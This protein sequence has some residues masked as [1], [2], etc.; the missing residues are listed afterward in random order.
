MRDLVLRPYQEDAIRN[1]LSSFDKPCSV[2]G[3]AATG[4][5]KTVLFLEIANRILSSSSEARVL[6]CAHRRELIQQPLE[7]IGQFWPHMIFDSGIVMSKKNDAHKR[8][9]VGTMQ[10]LAIG[11]RLDGI[12]RHGPITHIIVDEAHR[13]GSNS[14]LSIIDKCREA[15]N[16]LR[17]LGVTATP[18]RADGKLAD[19]FDKKCFDYGTKELIDLGYLV[20]PTVMGVYTDISV[21]DVSVTGSGVF[22]D[23]Q[24]SSLSSVFE[25]DNCFDQ[26]VETHAKYAIDK[27]GISFTVTVAGAY[28]LAEKFNEYGVS[29]IALDGT[30]SP[31]ERD[32]AISG[33]KSGRYKMI[34]NAMLYTEGFDL[35][36][37]EVCHLVRPY[38]QDGPWVQCVGRVLRLSPDTGKDAALVFDYLPQERSLEFSL[39]KRVR[40]MGAKIHGKQSAGC[41]PDDTN[42][43]PGF[44]I[45]GRGIEVAV[46]DYFNEGKGSSK[47]WSESESGWRVIGLGESS[48]EI[49]RTLVMSPSGEEMELWAVWKKPGERWNQAGLL[50]SGDYDQVISHGEDMIRKHGSKSLVGRNAEWRN[51]KPSDKAISFGRKLS[52]HSEEYNAGELSDAINEKLALQSVKR[53]RGNLLF[54]V[55]GDK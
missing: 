37:L 51:R 34:C 27:P 45:I 7:R 6:I 32:S 17:V 16:T 40:R 23:Y 20:R 14:Y 26:V 44:G 54:K 43:H 12:L 3:V 39:D 52:V 8:L 46:L 9:I 31:A 33:M 15:N 55:A 18:E 29:A 49:S 5:G 35:P 4:A 11:K 48:D 41:N 53:K 1:V 21:A 25:T 38:R 19:V 47:A 50:Y 24:T 22:R 13:V 36:M 28:A 2:L 10:T 42:I 30:S